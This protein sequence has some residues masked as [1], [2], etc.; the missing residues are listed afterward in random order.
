MVIVRLTS[1]R[2]DNQKTY[3]EKTTAKHAINNKAGP[4]TVFLWIRID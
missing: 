3:H 1:M 2:T 4:Y